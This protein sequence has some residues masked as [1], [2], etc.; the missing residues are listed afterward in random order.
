MKLIASLLIIAAGLT[1]AAAEQTGY[2]KPA[3]EAYLR[4]V[5]LWVAGVGVKIDDPKD[6]KELPDRKSVV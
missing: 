6:S 3:L 1:Q 4:H 2:D 5:E